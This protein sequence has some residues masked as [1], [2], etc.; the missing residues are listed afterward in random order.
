MRQELKRRKQE[1]F[2]YYHESRAIYKEMLEYL[3]TRYDPRRT[4]APER[5]VK[6]T[7]FDQRLMTEYNILRIPVELEYRFLEMLKLLIV[8]SWELPLGY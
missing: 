1:K 2:S 6:P 3:H 4:D 7:P 5:A 8:D